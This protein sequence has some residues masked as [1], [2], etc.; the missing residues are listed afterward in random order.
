VPVGRRR[1]SQRAEAGIPPVGR[2]R[3]SQWAAVLLE[4]PSGATPGAAVVLQSATGAAPRGWRCCS[5]R[6]SALLRAGAG[7][8]LDVATSGGGVATNVRRRLLQVVL[9]AAT[10][11]YHGRRRCMHH[12][13][14]DATMAWRHCYHGSAK[15]LPWLGGAATTAWRRCY[16]RAPALLPW[17]AGAATTARRRCYMV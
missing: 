8:V 4:S 15:V 12:G 5:N 2:R 13:D 3:C 16:H 17:L 7:V 1:S 14:G 9:R 10:L 6:P 11:C